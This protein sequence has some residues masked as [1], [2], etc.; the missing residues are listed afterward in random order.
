MAVNL[1]E[2]NKRL[3]NRVLELLIENDKLYN[4]L[5]LVKKDLAECQ[6]RKTIHSNEWHEANARIAEVKKDLDAEAARWLKEQE[7]AKE[8][9]KKRIQFLVGV[10]LIPILWALLFMVSY[11]IVVWIWKA[12][13]TLPVHIIVSLFGVLPS[14]VGLSALLVLLSR[15]LYKV[16][17]VVKDGM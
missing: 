11:C 2:D 4:E 7:V 9:R 12:E 10:F 5:A 14:F 6:E 16:W 15:S 3:A 13:T 1:E 8:I 17:L